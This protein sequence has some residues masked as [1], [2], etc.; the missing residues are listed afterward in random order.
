MNVSKQR[1]IKAAPEA[2]WKAI[3]SVEDLPSWLAGVQSASHVSGPAEGVGR[4]QRVSRVIYRHDVETEQ[5]VTIWEPPRRMQVRHI[6]ETSE[7]RELQGVQDFRMTVTVHPA[8]D[9]TNAL[10]EYSWSARPGLSWLLSVIFGGRT[11][12]RE[13]SDTLKKIDALVKV[14]GLL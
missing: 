8:G 10:I 4:L 2:V 5:E 11:M 7:G 14:K 12:G 3:A 1:T 6:K 13:L 9:R